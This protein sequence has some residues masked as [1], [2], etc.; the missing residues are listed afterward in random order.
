MPHQG[1]VFDIHKKTSKEDSTTLSSDIIRCFTSISRL[2]CVDDEQFATVTTF[3]V[4]SRHDGFFY[5]IKLA[6]SSQSWE[7]IITLSAHIFGSA[8]SVFSYAKALR[9]CKYRTLRLHLLI[10]TPFTSFL[11]SQKPRSTSSGSFLTANNQLPLWTVCLEQ[12]S[13]NLTQQVS[14]EPG[15]L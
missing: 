2:C 6:L 8:T 13:P 3:D 12:R 4:R 11:S 1:N 15:Q 5:L 9:P 10:T 14:R 7:G